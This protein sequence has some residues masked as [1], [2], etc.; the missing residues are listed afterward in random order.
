VLLG[1][2][3]PTQADLN[4]KLFGFPVR[5]HPFFWVIAVFLG[6]WHNPFGKGSPVQ[7]MLLWIV[8][9]FISI[10]V[11]E[12]GH[13]L[14][15][16]AFGYRPWIVLY[17][18]GGLACYN[19]A[20]GY[21][22]RGSDSWRQVLISVAGPGAG[23]VLALLVIG[24][25]AIGSGQ[26]IEF[27]LGGTFGIRISAIPVQ[28]EMLWWF[29][30]CM[31]G[32]SLV[33]GLINLLPVYPLDGGNI[34]R[35]LLLKVNPQEGIS[36]SLKMSVFTGIAVAALVLVRDVRAAGGNFDV[37]MLWVPALFGYL[38]YMSYVTLQSYTRQRPW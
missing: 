10:L 5:V 6:P 23:F 16:R 28:S 29:I 34:A 31:I 37:R 17:G 24:I 3:P 11:H 38:A 13:A 32:I 4:F 15:Q 14:V 30:Y 8:A 26:L 12:L 27:R 1:E 36:Q 18:M 35:E 21:R 20:D 7:P 25:V 9:L 19:P 33:W 22:A 2:P